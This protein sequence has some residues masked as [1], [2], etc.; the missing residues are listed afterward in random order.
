MSN[1]GGVDAQGMGQLSRDLS[2]IGSTALDVQVKAGLVDAGDVVANAA[3]RNASWSSRIPA[4][5]R[6]EATSRGVFVRAGGDKA[7]HAVTFEGRV[8]GGNRS[9]PVF[10]EGDRATWIWA[11]QP[12]RPFL[13]P[14]MQDNLDRGAEKV[15]DAVVKAF[16]NNGWQ[17]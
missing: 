8:D 10:A 15:A 13:M 12:A 11:E 3:R 1:T 5:V 14:A 17:A 4:S 2:R 6:T 16:L 7:P 9:H